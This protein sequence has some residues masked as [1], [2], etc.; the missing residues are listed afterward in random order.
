MDKTTENAV[1]EQVK[2][3]K[4]KWQ[5]SIDNRYDAAQIFFNCVKAYRKDADE[6]KAKFYMAF[7]KW[8]AERWNWLYIIGSGR[9]RKAFV[10]VHNYALGQDIANIPLTEQDQIVSKGLNVYSVEHPGGVL[11][12]LKRINCS[13]LRHAYDPLNGWKHRPVEEQRKMPIA[14]KAD[15][16][17][18]VYL[19]NDNDELQAK[20]KKGSLISK[21]KLISMLTFRDDDGRTLLTVQELYRVIHTLEQ[22]K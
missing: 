16:A 1:K 8:T 13:M 2:S 19:V 15:K 17:D 7:P 14:K 6:V 9:V 20:V 3:F 11:I 18:V 10:D 4:A 21:E 5:E 12:P 22:N